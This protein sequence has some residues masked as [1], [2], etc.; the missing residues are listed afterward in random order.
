MTAVLVAQKQAVSQMKRIDELEAHLAVK[1][2]ELASLKKEIAER[3]AQLD[4]SSASNASSAAAAAPADAAAAATPATA[5]SPKKKAVPA[6]GRCAVVMNALADRK[7]VE[8]LPLYEAHN[9]TTALRAALDVENQAAAILKR[10]V[11]ALTTEMQQTALRATKAIQQF[12]EFKRETGFTKDARVPMHTKMQAPTVVGASASASKEPSLARS[13]PGSAAGAAAA[14]GG[15]ASEG[16]AN[17]TGAAGAAASAPSSARAQQQQVET[18]AQRAERLRKERADAY[19][20]QLRKLEEH[21]KASRLLQKKL[22]SSLR[23]LARADDVQHETEMSVDAARNTVLTLDRDIRARRARLVELRE[24]QASC[25]V[26]LQRVDDR[27]V[28]EH[29]LLEMIHNEHRR[30]RGEVAD[31]AEQRR[32]WELTAK[33]QDRRLAELRERKAMIDQAIDAHGIAPHVLQYVERAMAARHAAAAAGQHDSGV[34]SPADDLSD[35]ISHY[36]D[37]DMLAPAEETVPGG[38]VMLL[39]SL[40]DK[41]AHR[42]RCKELLAEE[43]ATTA[44]AM[45]ARVGGLVAAHEYSED[46]LFVARVECEREVGDRVEAAKRQLAAFRDEYTVVKGSLLEE[47]RRVRHASLRHAVAPLPDMKFKDKKK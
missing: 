2:R 37:A 5:G 7:Y 10:E 26:E 39:T 16:A 34:V 1:Q 11:A 9:A 4:S 18:P 12:D 6:V 30:V 27:R 3:T 44:D 25:D 43:K 20:L 40:H 29:Q 17:T 21:L 38:V 35:I 45:R 47:Q 19:I 28:K 24:L 32:Q 14:T 13:S 8:H 33:A 46:K 36:A 42:V 22:E 31:V 41:L 23:D 15:D